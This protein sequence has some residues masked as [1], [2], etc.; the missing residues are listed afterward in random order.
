MRNE[1]HGENGSSCGSWASSNR[2]LLWI[3]KK[4]KGKNARGAPRVTGRDEAP[5]LRKDV[6]QAGPP[7]GPHGSALGGRH[8]NVFWPESG[9]PFSLCTSV[10]E[11]SHSPCSG[12]IRRRQVPWPPEAW[13]DTDSKL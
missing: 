6:I 8:N 3:K 4:K 10:P 13:G 5:G 2:K 11:T 7:R 1:E 9:S 12:G